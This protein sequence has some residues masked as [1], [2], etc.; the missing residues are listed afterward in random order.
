MNYLPTGPH[1][2]II[3]LAEITKKIKP[4]FEINPSFRVDLKV[5]TGF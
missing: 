2:A 1:Q 3:L 5:K 4:W